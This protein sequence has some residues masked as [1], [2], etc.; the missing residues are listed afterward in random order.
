MSLIQESEDLTTPAPRH[1]LDLSES[2]TMTNIERPYDL[3]GFFRW[4]ALTPS[5]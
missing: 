5:K 2:A 1:E 3:L 4:V